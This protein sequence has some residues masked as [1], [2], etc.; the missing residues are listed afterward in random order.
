MVTRFSILAWKI[1][2]A[3]EADGLQCLGPQ[4]L[5]TAEHSTFVL[6]IFY[7]FYLPRLL[8]CI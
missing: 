1:A 8:K 2:W 4:K 7:V 6:D 5:A 3:E